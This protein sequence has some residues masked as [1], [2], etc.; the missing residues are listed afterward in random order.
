[1]RIQKQTDFGLYTFRTKSRVQSTCYKSFQERFVL[2][3]DFDLVG[4]C[5]M[6]I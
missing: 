4:F 2:G 6:D 3:F 1:M 5:R